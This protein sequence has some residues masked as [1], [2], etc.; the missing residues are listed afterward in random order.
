MVPDP[1]FASLER[2]LTLRLV[3]VRRNE[4]RGSTDYGLELKNGGT[5]P[6]NACLGPGRR[7]SSGYSVIIHD[8]GCVRE[9]SIPPGGS[10]AWSET[11]EGTGYELSGEIHV[12]VEILNPRRCNWGCPGFYLRSNVLRMP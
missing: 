1:A 3:E 2:A 11:L 6:A 5:A 9:F 8:P 7:V 12:A 10:M 4:G